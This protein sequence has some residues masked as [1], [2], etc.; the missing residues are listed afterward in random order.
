M[1]VIVL[2]FIFDVVDK[3]ECYVESLYR[4]GYGLTLFRGIYGTARYGME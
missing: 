3:I 1:F 2:N 4:L